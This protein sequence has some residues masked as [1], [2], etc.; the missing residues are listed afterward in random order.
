M[1]FEPTELPEVVM[2]KPR[3]FGDA[4]GSFF[5]SWHAR[6]F[7]AAGISAHFVQDNRSHSTRHTLR[8]LHYQIRRPQ[9]KLVRVAQGDVFDVAV[10][11]RRS[12]PR[13]GHR[14]GRLLSDAN[15]HMLWVPPDRWAVHC[16]TVC[17]PVPMFWGSRM[18]SWISAMPSL[19]T[20]RSRPIRPNC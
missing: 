4:R 1:E 16:C 2:I 15:R 9:G 11:I 12:S 6:K 13:F 8:G 18:S 20:V 14:V 7:S 10:D 3:V 19:C 17:R 5:E